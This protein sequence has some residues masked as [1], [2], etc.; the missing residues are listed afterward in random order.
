MVNT[1]VLLLYYIM[2]T[3]RLQGG[4]IMLKNKRFLVRLDDLDWADFNTY[5]E[6][7]AWIRYKASAFFT[8]GIIIDRSNGVKMYEVIMITKIDRRNTL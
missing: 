3:I 8:S 4:E 5:R 1:N 7:R 2:N 6:A